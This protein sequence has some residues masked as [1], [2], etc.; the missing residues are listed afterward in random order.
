MKELTNTKEVKCKDTYLYLHSFA[1][2]VLFYTGQFDMLVPYTHT[3]SF[4]DNLAWQGVSGFFSSGHN[5]WMMN[6]S[7][8]GYWK[9]YQNLTHVLIRNAG[10]AVGASQ[11]K[12]LFEMVKKFINDEVDDLQ[13][14]KRVS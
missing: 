1:L 2:Q 6:R 7:L 13:R 8:V 12:Y 9:T 11:P 14:K 10:H 5:A 4:L 3:A